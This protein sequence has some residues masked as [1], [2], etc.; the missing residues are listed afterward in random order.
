ME[1]LVIHY[2]I[3]ASHSRDTQPILVVIETISVYI[4]I[5]ISATKVV[6]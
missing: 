6:T 2:V 1:H 3:T 4:F 5:R